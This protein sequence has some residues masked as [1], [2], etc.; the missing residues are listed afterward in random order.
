[1]VDTETGSRMTWL[2]MHGVACKGFR[3]SGLDKL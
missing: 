2:G 1:M 3:N